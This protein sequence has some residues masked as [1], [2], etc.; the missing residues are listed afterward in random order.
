MVGGVRERE[1]GLG[2]GLLS[3]GGGVCGGAEDDEGINQGCQDAL[4]YLV[5]A[6]ILL[7]Q[8]W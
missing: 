1:V 3:E 6:R 4:K 7:T 2:G 5:E 8:T